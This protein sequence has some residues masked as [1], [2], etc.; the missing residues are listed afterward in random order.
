MAVGPVTGTFTHATS[1][2]WFVAA[3]FAVAG[4]GLG[5]AMPTA[6]NTA[7]GALAPE[8]SGSG[9]A[10]ISSFRLVGATLG[11]AVLGTVLSSAYRSHLSLDG[12]PAA[13]AG[14][15]RSGV[16]DGI[17]VARAAG[18][19]PLLDMA[20]KPFAQGLDVML[21]VCAVMAA[22]GALLALLFIPRRPARPSGT[23]L[24]LPRTADQ[25][26]SKVGRCRQRRRSDAQPAR[27]VTASGE[28]S[29]L[30]GGP[31]PAGG[32]GEHDDGR[33]HVEP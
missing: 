31:L 17:E 5:L 28:A 33:V 4:I 2:A 1:G 15:V 32:A 30:G 3:W 16:A 20:R 8:R 25:T 22:V 11:V 19:A 6:T 24:D 21:W 14:T 29:L 12:L 18:S 9:S 7:L 10:V 27:Q 26:V 13:A 23:P